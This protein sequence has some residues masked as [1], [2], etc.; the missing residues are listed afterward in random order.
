MAISRPLPGRD[1]SEGREPKAL[2]A[3][4]RSRGL[5]GRSSDQAR[6][7]AVGHDAHL[8]LRARPGRDEQPPSGLGHD[9]DE[10]RL[11]AQLREH[12][13]LVRRRLGEHGVQGDDERLGKLLR[14]GEHVFAVAPAEDPVL[15]LQEDDVDVEP[16]DHARGADVVA[17]NRLRDRGEQAG[18]LRA[19]RLVHDRDEIHALDTVDPTQCRSQIGG[20]R[21]DAAGPRR[22]GGDDRCAQ[23]RLY[24]CGSS[25]PRRTD[26]L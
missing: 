26:T 1:Q 22:V 18:P 9:D 23:A 10:L 7:R 2:A 13:R 12:E 20:E 3:R 16:P 4:R 11:R 6:R 25:T 14:K 5:A 15:M 17:A 21:A 8:L 19:R 24:D